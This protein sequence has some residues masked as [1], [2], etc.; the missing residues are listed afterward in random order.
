MKIAVK[1]KIDVT[2]IDKARLF[3]GQK[4][5]Y[6]TM[7]SFINLDEQDQYGNNGMVTH[8]KNQGEE[9]APILGNSKVFWRDDQ[10]AYQNNPQPVHHAP[11]QSTD[12]FDDDIPF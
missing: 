2:K 12:S 11:Q 3:E 10:Q 6:L 4:G 9:R 1:I 5:K 8:K 7:T